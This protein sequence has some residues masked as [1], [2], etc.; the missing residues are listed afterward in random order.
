[1]YPVRLT[2]QSVTLRE[3]EM[4]DVDA[5]LAIVGDDRVT[6][7]LSFDS[8]DHAQV[9]AMVSG[10]VGRAHEKDRTEHYFAIESGAEFVGFVRLGF[11]GVKAAKIGYAIKAD[12]WGRGYA[13][14]A[15]VLALDFAFNQL[16][17]HRA[18]AAIGPDN[19]ASVAIVK[20]LGFTYEGRIRDHVYTNGQWCDS[21]LYS[22][23]A[24]DWA[25]RITA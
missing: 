20:R 12:C 8:R 4:S 5:T 11:S 9:E 18:S 22:V 17:L 19:R 13:T 16:K 14:E 3:F 24:D 2:G 7:W 15:V 6:S 21:L 1:M 23:L 10:I 25:D